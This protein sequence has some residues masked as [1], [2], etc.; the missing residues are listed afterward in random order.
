MR[1]INRRFPDSSGDVNCLKNANNISKLSRMLLIISLVAG[2]QI[3]ALPMASAAPAQP[4]I[5]TPDTGNFWIQHNWQAG[6]GGDATD[7]YYISIDG[8]GWVAYAQTSYLLEELSP[9]ATSTL[10]VYAYN[11]STATSS[12]IAE[13][14]VTLPNNE[15]SI[16][17]LDPTIS[18]NT[19]DTV[20]IDAGYS[21]EDSD[22]PSFSCSRTDLFTDFNSADGTGSWTPAEAG[23]YSV[24]FSVADGYGSTDT[25]T[26]DIVVGSAATAPV[27]TGIGN[28]EVNAGELLSFTVSATGADDIVYTATGLPNGA[29]LDSSSGAFS[30]TPGS[31]DV[32]SHEVTFTATANGLPDS[33][34][35]T[36]TVNEAADQAPV[37]TEIGDK[38]VKEGELLSFTVSAT[39][40]DNIVYTA[41]GLPEGATID[42]SSG[43]FSW[44]P[45][46][47]TAGNYDVTFTATA[48]GQSDSE[49]ITITVAHVDRAPELTSIGNKDVE[50]NELLS[51]T[52][53][54]TDPDGD[55]VTYS[56]KNLP[57]GATFTPSTATF[58]WTPGYD[59]SGNYDNIEFVATANGLSDSENITITVGDYNR[60]PVLSSIGSQSVDEGDDLKITL[61]ATDPEDNELTYSAENAPSDSSLNSTTGVFTW[62]PEDGDAG[63]YHVIFSVSDGTS[64]DSENVTIT[65]DEVSSSSS[66]SGS[67]SSSSSGSGGSTSSEKYENILLRDYVLKTTVLKDVESV[68]HFDKVDNCIN[69]VSFVSDVNGGQSKIVIEVLKDTSSQ[70]DS[71]APGN[72]YRNVN[73][74]IDTSLASSAIDDRKV[75]FKVEKGWIEDNNVNMSDIKLCIYSDGQWEQ[76]DTEF[77]SE[78]Q[79]YADFSTDIEEF[80]FFAI[81]YIDS[82]RAVTEQTPTIVTIPQ[83]ED[84]NLSSTADSVESGTET[85]QKSNSAFGFVVVLLI[86]GVGIIYWALRL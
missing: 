46:Y 30:W 78:N 86:A 8:G 65:V 50:E 54:A 38:N 85:S 74:L 29:T 11:A 75:S 83:A 13:S 42:S 28:K 77:V 10:Q 21:D 66:S 35:I 31:G 68:F 80:G 49:S 76:L 71:S 9:H 58:S 44:T 79:S 18:V 23:T 2:L 15:I 33:E 72:V 63:T 34:T 81:S 53:S 55:A 12:G 37:L 40:A 59:S 43:A 16:T 6:S 24:D 57:D 4:S 5:L 41:T 56:A 1:L 64:T 62:T 39:G 73:I 69:S 22:T 84:T 25:Q 36:I 32:G 52:I 67:S 20:S 60:P 14:A 3:A 45:E 17:D 27:L 61:S 70:V 47:G 7:S 26:V 51:F 48:N 82:T 19:G